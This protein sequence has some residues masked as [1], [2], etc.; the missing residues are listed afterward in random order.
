MDRGSRSVKGC[1]SLDMRPVLFILCISFL[2]LPAGGCS[3]EEQYDSK[4]AKRVLRIKTPPLKK[5]SGLK[6]EAGETE[7]T[8]SSKED[9][10]PAP[11]EKE[12]VAPR[13]ELPLPEKAE[14]A[15]PALLTEEK[16]SQVKV[17]EPKPGRY[18][19]QKGDSLFSIAGR[20]EVYNDPMKWPSLFRLNMDKLG[21][22]NVEEGFQ[23][24]EL[25][26]GL[27]LNFVTPSEAKENRDKLGG[28]PWVVNVMS[29]EGER[30]IAPA[31]IALMKKGYCVYLTEAR[32]KGK[33]WV[34]V[35]V[36]FFKDVSEAEEVR[37]DIMPLVKKGWLAKAG[38]REMEDSG[39]Y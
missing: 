12:V 16:P 2:F 37:R 38:N 27:E 21:Q 13:E 24:R 23:Q 20:K 22:V 5:D 14:E 26:V 35:R 34:R 28:R 3:N 18:K 30:W 10:A 7:K 1:F 31:A 33:K 36:G 8:V 25:P 39:G 19:V 9:E 17:E 6:A 15:G 11:L 4:G 29:V 32:A